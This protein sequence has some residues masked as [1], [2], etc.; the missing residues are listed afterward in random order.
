MALG[1]SGSWSDESTPN[2]TYFEDSLSPSSL[3][4]LNA[5]EAILPNNFKYYNDHISK[6]QFNFILINCSINL[7]KILYPEMDEGK[8]NLRFFI[9]EILRRSKT[10]IQSLQ[11]ACFYL[12]KMMKSNHDELP[13]CPKKLFLGLLIISSK[14]NQDANYSFKTWLKICGCNS[15]DDLSKRSDLNLQ[16]LRGVEMKCLKLLNY[17]CYINNS[18]YE[19]WCNILLIFGYDFI[20]FHKIFKDELIWETSRE[21]IHHKLIKWE[22]F[23]ISL[24]VSK[25]NAFRSSFN[26]YYISQYGTKVLVYDNEKMQRSFNNKRSFISNHIG[27]MD[28][29]V[30]VSCE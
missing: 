12:L 20:R 30:K 6:S 24:D 14:F 7:I 28:K 23:L 29:K 10:S 16:T 11:I 9:V 15:G 27:T 25:L 4:P 21:I 18:K 13:A 26:D 3:S 19:N 8:I 5:K 17:E 1:S 22:K 2:T